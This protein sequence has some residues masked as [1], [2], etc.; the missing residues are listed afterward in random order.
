MPGERPVT[1]EVGDEGVVIVPEGLKMMDHKPEPTVGAFPVS[2]AV[3]P[4]TVRSEPVAMVGAA[5]TVTEV[6]AVGLEQD[7]KNAVTEYVPE[8]AVVAGEMEGSSEEAVKPLG[9]VHEYV[10]PLTVAAVRERSCPSQRG[11][12]L[13]AGVG[14]VGVGL[15]VTEVVP[16]VLVHPFADAV[17]E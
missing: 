14:V 6:V 10:A 3:I 2:V 5:S 12:L 17:T 8:A 16:A 9:P 4:Q 13:P 1:P 7:P 11:E 15:T